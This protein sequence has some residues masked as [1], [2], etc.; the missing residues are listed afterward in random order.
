MNKDAFELFGTL[1]DISRQ[2]RRQE[3]KFED[4]VELLKS[5]FEEQS[6]EKEKLARKNIK[7]KEKLEALEEELRTKQDRIDELECEEPSQKKSRRIKTEYESDNGSDDESDDEIDPET[8][9]KAPVYVAQEKGMNFM[10]FSEQYG[11]GTWTTITMTDPKTKFK[12]GDLLR[13][14]YGTG[15]VDL[16]LGM[17]LANCL[18]KDREL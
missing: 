4:Q 9:A 16:E 3:S 14:Q 2:K 13:H 11:L 1:A 15:P 10:R 17:T 18:N 5:K 12:Y 7:L 8:A 6:E